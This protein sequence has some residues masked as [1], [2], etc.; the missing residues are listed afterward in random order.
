AEVLE[1]DRMTETDAFK[2][3]LPYYARD[4]KMDMERWQKFAD[5]AFKYG[6]IEDAVDV[7]KILW[8]A[9]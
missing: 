8:P 4:Q 2:L 7:K 9:N 1:A 5:F 6:L 3:T